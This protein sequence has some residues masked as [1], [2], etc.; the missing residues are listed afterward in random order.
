MNYSKNEIYPNYSQP[1]FIHSVLFELNSWIG[2]NIFKKKG[3]FIPTKEP[4]LIDIG[5]GSN[6]TDGWTHIDFYRNRVRKFWKTRTKE[7][8]PEVETDL[9]F[10]LNCQDNIADGIYS[11]HTLEHLYP[12]HAY[13]LLNEIFRILKPGCWLRINVL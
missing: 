7:R 5:V 12:N 4:F 8:Y 2:R 6:Y 13:N 1:K 9:R 10:P 3:R 11:G